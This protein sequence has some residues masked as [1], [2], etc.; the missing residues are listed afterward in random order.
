MEGGDI[1]KTNQGL[2]SLK[3]IIIQTLE[4]PK[5]AV[6]PSDGHDRRQIGSTRGGGQIFQTL[7]I[8][9]GGQGSPSQGHGKGLGLVANRF[10][11]FEAGFIVF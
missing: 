9:S 7:A 11:G 8:A 3:K 5:A 1:G 4:Q 6:A 2:G 10:Q